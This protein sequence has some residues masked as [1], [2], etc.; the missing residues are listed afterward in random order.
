MRLLLILGVVLVIVG[1]AV[2]FVPIPRKERHG[3]D[4]GGLSVGFET[5][6]REKLHPAVGAV[7]IGG[8]VVLLIAGRRGAR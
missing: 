8:G 6:R 4:A 7:L 3:L 1:I 2:L 5:T